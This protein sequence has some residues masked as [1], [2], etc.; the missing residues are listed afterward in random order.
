MNENSSQWKIIGN[1]KYSSKNKCLLSRI[2]TWSSNCVLR[3]NYLK[4]SIIHPRCIKVGPQWCTVFIADFGV[5]LHHIGSDSNPGMTLEKPSHL[6]DSDVLRS[7]LYQSN[8]IVRPD[9][10][11]SYRHLSFCNSQW[12]T[13]HFTLLYYIIPSLPH[14]V[15]ADYFRIR[16][17][18]KMVFLL[19]VHVHE[20]H[21]NKTYTYPTHN[22][23]YT[24]TSKLTWNKP[25]L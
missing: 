19:L 15:S 6:L 4:F 11:R 17:R 9:F 18:G 8:K 10:G 7:C 24:N 21:F 22:L 16:Y 25:L 12:K 2:F 23:P 14:P 1:S 13:G 3:I 5:F 20:L